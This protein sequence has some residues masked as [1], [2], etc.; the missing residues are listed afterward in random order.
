MYLDDVLVAS[1][2]FSEHLQH[3]DKVFQR[4]DKYNLRLKMKKCNWARQSLP[5]LGFTIS[6]LGI[7]PD[8]AN[9]EKLLEYKP[10]TTVTQVRAFLGLCG[11]YRK[12]IANFADLARP[13]T[14]LTKK[15][16]KFHWTPSCQAAF[17]ALIRKLTKA[18]LLRYPRFDQPFLV[19]VNASQSA[20]GAM[21][22]QVFDGE[23]HPIAYY[24]KVF[25]PTES[26][27]STVERELFALVS[28]LRHWKH[29]LYGHKVVVYS[30]QQSI[31]WGIKQTESARLTKWTAQI[32]EF[33]VE[34]KYRPGPKNKCADFLSWMH[35]K[36]ETSTHSQ[37][38][39]LEVS[40]L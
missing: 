32:N 4:L 6:P 3:L 21:L 40:A 28:A 8:P 35:P 29:Y 26:R 14:N 38:P 11:Y 22:S 13:L 20:C 10:P 17:E 15:S 37:P 9:I 27:Y 19:A 7:L 30:D 31:S 5:F 25:Q 33:D 36:P 16:E 1:K 39:T 18:P 23:E 24:S 2:T 34:L 12:F